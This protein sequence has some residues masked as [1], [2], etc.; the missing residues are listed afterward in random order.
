MIINFLQYE[1]ME[2]HEEIEK[3][4]FCTTYS[5]GTKIIVDYNNET[6]KVEKGEK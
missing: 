1:F 5:D 3:N 2:K 4:V 6:Y